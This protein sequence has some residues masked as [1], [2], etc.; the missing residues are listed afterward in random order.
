MKVYSNQRLAIL[1]IIIIQ[2]C[3][4]LFA[5]KNILFKDLLFVNY[6]DG[7]KNYFTFISYLKQ[8]FNEGIFIFK[9]MNYPYGDYLFYAGNNP[10]LAIFVKLFSNYIFDVTSYSF[11]IYNFFCIINILISTF[12]VYKILSYILNSKI[13]IYPLSLILPWLCPQIIRLNVGH[14][15][16]S[17]SF[18]FLLIT[19]LLLRF[20]NSYNENNIKSCIINSILIIFSVIIFTFIHLYYIGLLLILIFSFFFF[21]TI[22]EFIKTK[23]YPKL[24][25]YF[26]F[27]IIFSL[28]PVFIIKLIDKFYD[29]R[30]TIVGG[31]DWDTWSLTFP[32]LFTSYD[33][34]VIKFPIEYVNGIPYESHAFLGNFALIATLIL[35]ITYIFKRKWFLSFKKIFDS[36]K[37]FFI[38]LLLASALVSLL[39]A[40]GE[41]IYIFNNSYRITNYLTPFYYLHKI[42][43]SVTQFRCL[44]RFNWFFFWGF[45]FCVA[46]II[47]YYLRHNKSMW[48]KTIVFGLIICS[49]IDTYDMIT[50][51]KKKKYENYLTNES[52]IEEMK[53]LTNKVDFSKYQAIL[54][55]PYYHVGSENYDY[56]IDPIESFCTQTM[57]LSLMSNLPL[58]SSKMSRTAEY[59]VKEFFELFI[60]EDF[61][62]DLSKLLSDKPILVLYDKKI[63]NE[64]IEK[65]K[66]SQYPH[67]K[68]L[69][70]KTADIIEKYNME[71]LSEYKDVLYLY[72][73]DVSKWKKH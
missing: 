2:S 54:P 22:Y 18:T 55:I 31:Y 60:E 72:H 47:D 64:I 3:L 50:V 45:N 58:M 46:F 73:F 67:S 30:R 42:T 41:K 7:I 38:L 59:Q 52:Y 63:H 49:I 21:W 57:Q 39:I 56:T 61:P 23:R 51:F 34:N 66:K 6:Y 69:V 36:D 44:G 48:L 40:F 15:N 20:Y 5:F 13:L 53:S 25:N 43:D 28:I 71:L 29:F 16:L 14:F 4:L 26:S 8:N 37:G 70:Y 12:F 19:Y 11:E 65:F 24:L 27:I 10:I 33:H 68:E 32:A 9:N 1:L 17:F 62:K 35:I